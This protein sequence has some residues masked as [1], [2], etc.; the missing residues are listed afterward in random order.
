MNATLPEGTVRPSKGAQH[1]G[2]EETIS[3][4]KGNR[5]PPGIMAR[6]LRWFAAGHSWFCGS[7]IVPGLSVHSWTAGSN[8]ALRHLTWTHVKCP[9]RN[10]C[11]VLRCLARGGASGCFRG[12]I[13]R[14]LSPD[15]LACLCHP[16][17]QSIFSGLASSRGRP[18][19]LARGARTVSSP[20]RIQGPKRALVLSVCLG[21]G[22][23]HPPRE[24][25]NGYKRDLL[26]RVASDISPG[27]QG[28]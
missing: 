1:P 3:G 17:S 4:P 12:F 21:G 24:E 6:H 20:H 9:S 25:C 8:S 2:Q 16:S 13:L 19:P 26:T 10:A 7:L 22:H 23:P 27:P 28:R 14:S 18:P 15:L 5:P 11:K